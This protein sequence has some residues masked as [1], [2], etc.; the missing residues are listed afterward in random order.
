M[1][2]GNVSVSV[3]DG[4]SL[5]APTPARVIEINTSALYLRQQGVKLQALFTGKRGSEQTLTA[6]SKYWFTTS[7][8]HGGRCCKV[9]LGVCAGEVTFRAKLQALVYDILPSSLS[10]IFPECRKPVL[11]D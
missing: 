8:L 5:P 3:S 4:S 9:V 10:G 6:I 11:A 7:F 1:K 2:T